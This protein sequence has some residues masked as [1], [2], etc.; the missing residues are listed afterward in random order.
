MA[1]EIMNIIKNRNRIKI[2]LQ[3][4][5]AKKVIFLVAGPPR[6]GGGK[7]LATKN[8]FLFETVGKVVVF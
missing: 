2:R 3:R 8:N 4:E 5:A 7:G 1:M 6:G